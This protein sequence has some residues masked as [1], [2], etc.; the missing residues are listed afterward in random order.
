MR[1]KGLSEGIYAPFLKN[2]KK[3]FTSKQYKLITRLFCPELRC[4]LKQ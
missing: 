2:Q 1:L 4:L 3:N